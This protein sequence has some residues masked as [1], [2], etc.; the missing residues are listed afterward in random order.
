MCVYVGSCG[1]MT[2]AVRYG[3]FT[4]SGHWPI[5]TE[6]CDK[7][8]GMSL[9]LLPAGAYGHY[10]FIYVKIITRL[11]MRNVSPRQQNVPVPAGAGRTVSL[12]SRG[13]Y[14]FFHVLLLFTLCNVMCHTR[15]NRIA[16]H[17][18][19]PLSFRRRKKFC[20]LSGKSRKGSCI[21]RA[22][23]FFLNYF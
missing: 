16:C 12:R 9:A 6:R 19:M 15:S 14:F 7:G 3:T 10:V 20:L 1:C 18:L 22:E 2:C 11:A 4:G 13:D 5:E 23:W 8:S 21:C 17:K